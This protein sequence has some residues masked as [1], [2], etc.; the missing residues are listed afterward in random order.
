[1]FATVRSNKLILRCIYLSKRPWVARITGLDDTRVFSR[2]FVGVTIGSV[3]GNP[4]EHEAQCVV[5]LVDGEVLE[6]AN[7]AYH[8][9]PPSR[10]LF[11]VSNNRLVKTTEEDIKKHFGGLID[12]EIEIPF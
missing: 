12:E 6:L 11:F 2:N 5:P 8:D 1:M 10:G 9:E 7:W 4:N 3:E